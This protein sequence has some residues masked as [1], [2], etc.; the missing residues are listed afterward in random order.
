MDKGKRGAL[1]PHGAFLHSPIAIGSAD[2]TD[3]DGLAYVVEASSN[4]VEKTIEAD[5]LLHEHG[6][7]TLLV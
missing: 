7:H 2:I 1:A 4:C 6:V 3:L 5:H